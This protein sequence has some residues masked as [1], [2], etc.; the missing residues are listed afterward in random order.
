MNSK[1]NFSILSSFNRIFNG[2]E[3]ANSFKYKIETLAKGST[4]TLSSINEFDFGK[5]VC[6]GTNSIGKNAQEVEIEAKRAPDSPFNLLISNITSS[7]VLLE[8]TLASNGGENETFLL[9]INDQINV[10]ISNN[11]DEID[12]NSPK[13]KTIHIKSK[14]KNIQK[15]FKIL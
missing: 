12:S 6:Q 14:F 15:Q 3:I 5:Y 8:W 1:T 13:T 9:N 11:F 4:L 2:V 7:S 10:T